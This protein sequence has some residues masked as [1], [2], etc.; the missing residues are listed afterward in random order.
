[1]V[2][3]G[4]ATVLAFGGALRGVVRS[5]AVTGLRADRLERGCGRCFAHG[6]DRRQVRADRGLGELESWIKEA[7]G[8]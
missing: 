6:G 5:V 7:Q 2:T 4:V 3:G 1:M 8:S